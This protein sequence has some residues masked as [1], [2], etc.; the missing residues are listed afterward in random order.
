VV[1]LGVDSGWDGGF[2][3]PGDVEPG[4]RKKAGSLEFLEVC[5]EF[6]FGDVGRWLIGGCGVVVG[7]LGVVKGVGWTGAANGGGVAVH[8]LPGKLPSWVV[9]RRVRCWEVW[10]GWI[11]GGTGR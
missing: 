6:G 2:C 3:C 5:G 8:G 7:V 11:A 4:G 1:A 10:C 9:G